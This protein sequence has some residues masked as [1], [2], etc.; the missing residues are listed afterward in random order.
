MSER[1]WELVNMTT[2][3]LERDGF[4]AVIVHDK[5]LGTFKPYIRKL[6]E[7]EYQTVEALEKANNLHTAMWRCKRWLARSTKGKRQ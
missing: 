2:W 4:T 1:R 5:S 3:K 6:V 7:R